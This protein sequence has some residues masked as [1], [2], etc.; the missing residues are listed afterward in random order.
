MFGKVLG[1]GFFH[2]H[3]VPSTVNIHTLVELDKTPINQK[4]G[5]HTVWGEWRGWGAS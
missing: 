5:N 3:S 1:L 2:P 4:D